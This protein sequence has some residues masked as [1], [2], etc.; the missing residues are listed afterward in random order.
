MTTHPG[1]PRTGSL[2]DAADLVVELVDLG[3]AREAEV[4]MAFLGLWTLERVKGG[5]MSRDEAD[6]LFT[7][8]DV[9]VGERP[10]ATALSEESRDLVT[11]GEHFHHFGEAWGTDPAELRRMAYAIL[12]RGRPVDGTGRGDVPPSGPDGGR[13]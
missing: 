13:E 11:E 2:S 5:R 4:A 10:G 1:S 7:A 6:E 9:A 12:G 3:L 8:L